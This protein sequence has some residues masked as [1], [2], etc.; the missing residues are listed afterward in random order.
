MSMLKVAAGAL[1]L[2]LTPS[3][4]HAHVLNGTGSW[5]DELVCLVPAAIMVV[6]VIVLGRAPK[7][8]SPKKNKP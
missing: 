3:L 6:L 7:A 8:G 2:S 5:V 4:A 1:A